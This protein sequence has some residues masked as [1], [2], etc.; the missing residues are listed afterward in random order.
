MKDNYKFHILFLL[1]S[2][3]F[4]VTAPKAQSSYYGLEFIENKG[5]WD[6]AFRFKGDVGNGAFFIQDQGYTILQHHEA[7]YRRVTDLLH[8][9]SH[10]S[11]GSPA[12]SNIKANGPDGIR[13]DLDN[14]FNVRSHAYRVQFLNSLSG[15]EVVPDRALETYNNYFIGDDPLKW[16]SHVKIYQL[17]TYKNIYPGVDIRYYSEA[18]QLKYDLILHPGADLSRIVMKYDGAEKLSVKDKQLIIKTSVGEAKE[19]PPYAYQVMAGKRVEVPCAYE[20]KGDQVKFKTDNYDKNA[21]LVIDPTLVFS[22]FSGSSV[23]NWGFTAT[24]GNDGSLY[25][26]GIVFGN[27]YPTT[28]GAFQTNFQ[29]GGGSSGT[30]IGITRF[31]PNGNARIFSTYIGGNGDDFP[32]S[33]FADPQG[34]VVI[35]GRTNSGNY[36]V[37]GSNF[38]PLGSYDISL[39]K[40]NAAG[41]ALIGSLR[42]GG[43]GE[44]GGNI[45]PTL[46]ASTAPVSLLYN[47]GDNS[48][49]EVILDGANNVYIVSNTKST[50]FP[51]SAGAFQAVGGGNQ[52]GVVLKFNA[53]LST[54]LFSSYI[55]GS[56]D[57]GAFNLAL[58]PL[59]GNIYVTGATSS[60]NFPGNKAGSVQAVYQGAI[61]GYIAIVNNNGSALTRSTFLGTASVDIIY[62][63]QFD[64]NGFPY[65]MGITRGAWPVVNATY[66]NAGAKQFIAKLQ[67]DLSNYIYSTV[68]GAPNALPNISPVAFL[69]DRCENVY[70]SGW[71]GK[72]DPCGAAGGFDLQTSG[73]LGMPTT[74]DAIRG[75]SP[76]NRDF[77]F[78][79]L[80]KDAASQLYGSFFGQTGGWGEHVDGGTSRFDSRGAIYQAICASCFGNGQASQC[81]GGQITSP[82]PTTPG[83]VGPAN[84]TGTQNCN[85]GVLKI[86]FD[87]DGVKAG[88]QSSINGQ[89]ND[90]AGCVPLR[91]DFTDTI[92]TGASYEWDFGD[93]SPR[94]TTLNPDTSHTYNIPGL[95]RVML[96]SIDSTRCIPR[97]TSYVNIL[98]R[99]DKANLNLAEIK[100]PPCESLTYQ[101]NNLSVSPP[102][103]PFANNSF[104]W[105]FGD[106][107]ARVTAGLNSVTHTYASAG[108]Y[109]V[110]LI[111]ADPNYCNSPDSITRTI[112]LAPNVEALFTTPPAG[113]V[114]HTA[115]FTNTS[116]AGQTFIWDFGDGTNFT[117]P[118]PPPHVYS[119][120]G[121]YTITLVANDPATCNLTDTYS[122]TITVN[123]R[124]GAAFTFTPN[125]GQENTPTSFINLSVGASSYKWLFGDGD[126]SN[127]VNPVHQFNATGTF[128]TC[129][130][131]INET[132]CPD[133]VC[134]QVSA[135]VVPGIDVPNAFTPNDDGKNDVVGVRGF[136]IG[137]MNFRIYNRWGQMVFQGLHPSATWNGK[138][139][140]VLQPMDAYAYTLDVEFTNGTKI[141]K[142][143][144]ITLIR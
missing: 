32:H 85:L 61:D 16:K 87:F 46:S 37:V 7:D 102:G 69:V 84:G 95:Y 119:A 68:F 93:G 50:N 91:V 114:P 140:G 144:D 42:I 38:G 14:N 143:G 3:L 122:T 12:N 129:L 99:N 67:P 136:G 19:L 33:L 139:K 23:G 142:K 78:F 5:Q 128:N 124:P 24:P 138:F 41:T 9:H 75:N 21:T 44:D 40:L 1:I 53:D 45:N 82:Y 125:P 56:E 60:A 86:A 135:I 134:Q 120:P 112:R 35:L 103:K 74:P 43:A 51:V 65:V 130:I 94:L 59:N 127:L 20:V 100:L 70:I 92:A 49:S 116:L 97:D 47:Y 8:G 22:S 126:S 115:V 98:A 26:G 101:F 105:D 72:Q 96:I 25:G 62:G 55:G 58:N 104:I 28:A 31:S 89:A 111:L 6:K 63:V 108:T 66:S 118:N 13:S 133:T 117:G 110:K 27:G 88:V 15:A 64:R 141:T 18:G 107:T 132:G 34:N 90:T 123:P 113:C 54:V 30:D 71:G 29:G 121:N 10:Q 76:D 131:A 57:D 106:N 77:Y 39:T 48:R 83:V 17:L 4:F 11:S 73:T 36:P 79:V 80:R 81:P 137:K 52:D 2:T 109:N